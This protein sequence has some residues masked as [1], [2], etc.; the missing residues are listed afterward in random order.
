MIPKVSISLMV[1]L[2]LTQLAQGQD[3][4]C[5]TNDSVTICPSQP[6]I[7]IPTRETPS[8]DGDVEEMPQPTSV[9]R[10]PEESPEM[11]PI[12]TIPSLDPTPTITAV[13]LSPT[14]S[15]TRP[16]LSRP[17]KT[18]KAT[19]TIKPT[20]TAKPRP[21]TVRLRPTSKRSDGANKRRLSSGASS[22]LIFNTYGRVEL[23]CMM[24]IVVVTTALA[25]LI[26]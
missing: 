23:A 19:R 2:L 5:F 12:N 25:V 11:A 10:A 9:P 15:R 1:L 6:G 7:M 20:R 22:L 3:D 17:S 4:Q 14:S 16:T 24:L 18:A 26:V 21:A 13:F 8:S